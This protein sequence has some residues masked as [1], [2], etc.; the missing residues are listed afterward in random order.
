M[1]ARI[2]NALMQE[3]GLRAL[4]REDFAVHG[5][6][7]SKPGFRAVA[8]YR[9]GIWARTR[10]S[11]ALRFIAA[12]VHRYVNRFVRNVYGIEI[13]FNATIG[14]R[15]CV[16]HQGGIIVH[17][18][19][20]IGDD[21]II[22]QGVT[23]GIGGVSRGNSGP[24]TAP[25]LGDRVDI[26]AGAVVV[27]KVRIGDDVNIGPN[28]VVM[29]D[30]PPFTTVIAPPARFIQRPKPEANPAPIVPATDAS[31]PE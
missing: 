25:E 28:A 2:D 21:C 23:L 6:D 11:G 12:L 30:V 22:R 20:V 19:A 4:V 8:V 27:G 9:F 15:F 18:F 14:R 31:T 1:V 7:W 24:E 26:G 3:F 10:R 13:S 17:Q 16:G 5:R 29:V